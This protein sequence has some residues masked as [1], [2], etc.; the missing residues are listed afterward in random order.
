MEH[1]ADNFLS[2]PLG[3]VSRVDLG[4][5]LR[6]VEILDD[7]FKQSAIREPGTSVQAP[8]TSRMLDDMLASNKVNILLEEDRNRLLSFLMTVK[9]QAPTLHMSFNADPSPLFIQRLMK[10]LREEIHP[11]VLVQVGLQ[12]NIGA[13]CILRTTNKYFD[14]SL[15]EHFKQQRHILIEHMRGAQVAAEKAAT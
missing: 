2:L 13:G 15:R 9:K 10:Y 11:L 1:N 6:E 8:K 12:P 3:V 5:L 4:R 7:F 14:F